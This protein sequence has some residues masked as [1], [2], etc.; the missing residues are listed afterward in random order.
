[1]A[2]QVTFRRG[3]NDLDPV[4]IDVNL[5]D[6]VDVVANRLKTA[7][8]NNDQYEMVVLTRISTQ[9]DTIVVSYLDKSKCFGDYVDE[10]REFMYEVLRC[11]CPDKAVGVPLRVFV[12]EH[13]R[14]KMLVLPAYRKMTI[15]QWKQ[16]VI[17]N[18]YPNEYGNSQDRYTFWSVNGALDNNRKTVNTTLADYE[19]IV[20]ADKQVNVSDDGGSPIF[21]ANRYVPT[22]DAF[23]INTQFVLADYI[24]MEES[25]DEESDEDTS[26]AT[27]VPSNADVVS[28]TEI[29]S[30]TDTANA[31]DGARSE[32]DDDGEGL[33]PVTVLNKIKKSDG[34]ALNQKDDEHHK[35]IEVKVPLMKGTAKLYYNYGASTTIGEMKQSIVDKF[36]MEIHQFTIYLQSSPLEHYDTIDSYVTPAITCLDLVPR[37]RGGGIRRVIKPH[38]KEGDAKAKF[39]A[40]S[41]ESLKSYLEE[42]E[43][44]SII[45]P[46][47]VSP[48]VQSMMNKMA[49][50]KRKALEGEDVLTDGLL[51]LSDEQLQSLSQIFDVK[52]KGQ[53]TE[54]KLIKAA[55]I[56]IPE[57]EQVS[58]FVGHMIKHKNAVIQD[59]LQTYANAFT[60]T[61]AGELTYDNDKFARAV[62]DVIKIRKGYAMGASSANPS[63]EGQVGNSSN[64]SCM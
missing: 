54:Q 64:C 40:K 1:M 21:T 43:T 36:N 14:G 59:F 17:D 10:H 48:L 26:S 62:A 34:I 13:S 2:T 33:I 38:L 16:F 47:E 31:T 15:R 22:V 39:I 3:M 56:I 60:Q 45:T 23:H 57:M 49:E 51:S 46:P 5:G 11:D 29:A 61:R 20:F 42:C 6:Q 37:I 55:Y 50:I 28:V 9:Y 52:K 53:Y 30:V 12:N 44:K 4:T 18:A 32:P 58:E 7:L 19:V 27:A 8:N 25:D 41:I 63:N 35:T 24:H